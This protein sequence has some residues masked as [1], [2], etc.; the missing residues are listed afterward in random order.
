MGQLRV[1]MAPRGGGGRA[2]RVAARV[3]EVEGIRPN[4]RAAEARE[5][6]R[7]GG[8]VSLSRDAPGQ[9]APTPRLDAICETTCVL[10]TTSPNLCCLRRSLRP[11]CVFHAECSRY[12]ARKDL[13]GPW[14]SGLHAVGKSSTA[15]ACFSNS[16]SILSTLVRRVGP[17]SVAVEL[18]RSRTSGPPPH[19][20]KKCL[21]TLSI[22]SSTPL[23]STQMLQMLTHPT[24]THTELTELHALTSPL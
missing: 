12:A 6:C 17:V 16:S 19:C 4:A 3:S 14:D 20:G 10:S 7:M 8:D 13:T 24:V 21:S 2:G 18:P 23:T 5:T 22:A 1:R 15:Q 9:S 11:A